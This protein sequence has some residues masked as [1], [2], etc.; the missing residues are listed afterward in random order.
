MHIFSKIIVHIRT[1]RWAI[2]EVQ[3][4]DY[5]N[6]YFVCEGSI[7]HLEILALISSSPIP[8]ILK[9]FRYKEDEFW[10]IVIIVPLIMKCVKSFSIMEYSNISK[11]SRKYYIC[12]QGKYLICPCMRSVSTCIQYLCLTEIV[13]IQD[14]LTNY[15]NTLYNHIPKN[16]THTTYMPKYNRPGGGEG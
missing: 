4:V 12:M 8:M 2:L 5:L 13:S 16:V 6:L 9:N 7:H 15:F 10:Y 3:L 1:F 11:C 14:N